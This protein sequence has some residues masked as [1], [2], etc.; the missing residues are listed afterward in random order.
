MVSRSWVDGY[1]MRP[2]T[3]HKDLEQFHE[4]LIIASACLGGEVPKKIM[5]DDLHAAEEAIAWFKG[6]WG[7]DYYL[8]IQR[9]KVTD[10]RQ[11]ANREVY[12][13]Q[14]KVNAVILEL[15]EK[16]G[17]KVIGRMRKPSNV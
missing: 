7:D 10:P 12:E 13:L 2:R 14:S 3:D 1:Y 9:H 6:I 17:V 4:G 8:E 11:R 16:H 15:A 5:A